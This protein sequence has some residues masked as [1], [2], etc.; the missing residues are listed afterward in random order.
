[1]SLKEEFMVSRD[2]LRSPQYHSIQLYRY[3]MSSLIRALHSYIFTT[4][5]LTSWSEFEKSLNDARTLDDLYSIHVVYIKK[6]LFRCLLNNRSSS[7][8]K[9]LNDIFTVI[10]RFHHLLNARYVYLFYLAY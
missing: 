10:L 7:I 4:C 2:L 8:M 9:I 1:M 3:I 5:L 6:V